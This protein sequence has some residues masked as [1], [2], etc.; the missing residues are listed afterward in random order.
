M[1]INQTLK[2][3]ENP[4]PQ[5]LNTRAKSGLHEHLHASIP[6]GGAVERK[7]PGMVTE[8]RM[9]EREMG[10]PQPSPKIFTMCLNLLITLKFPYFILFSQLKQRL[11]EPNH[12]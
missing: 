7:A 1:L 8:L 4:K 2:L 5:P 11:T 12:A 6:K 10:N 9:T 3:P